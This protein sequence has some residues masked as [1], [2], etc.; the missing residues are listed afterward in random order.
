MEIDK[1]TFNQRQ[2]IRLSEALI[3][4][5]PRTGGSSDGDWFI[6]CQIHS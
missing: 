3:K 5:L 6:Y 2:I 4:L 1:I